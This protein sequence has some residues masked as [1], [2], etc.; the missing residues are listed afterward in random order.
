MKIGTGR[1]VAKVHY[2]SD[3]LF[4]KELG[5]ALYKFI[6]DKEIIK[7]ENDIVIKDDNHPYDYE[8]Y[9]KF[10]DYVVDE[11]NIEN[12]PTVYVEKEASSDYTGGTYRYKGG[13]ERIK[14]RSKGRSLMDI[15]RSIAHELVHHKQKEDGMF[16]GKEVIKDIPE[17][18]GP[19]ER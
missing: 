7:E 15:L 19:I 13:T 5:D 14:V 2:P 9:D 1:L 17:V 18:G 12:P 16:E 8:D 6:K 11:L 3:D 4:G 10:I